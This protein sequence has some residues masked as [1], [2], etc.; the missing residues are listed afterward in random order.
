MNPKPP[1]S[2]DASDR[3]IVLSRVFAAPRELVW[4]AMTDAKQ[5]VHWW[6]PRGFTTTIKEMDFRVGGVW[7][8]TMHGP[9][10]TNYPNESVFQEIVPLERVVYAH[11]GG[12]E[13]GPDVSFTASWTFEGVAADQ[14]RLTLRMV[15]P[16]AEHRDFIVKEFGAVEGGQQTLER[17]SE[18]LAGVRSR[19]FTIT[20]EFAAP[21][22]LVWQIWSERD[23]LMRWFGP[24]GFTTQVARMDLRPGGMFHYRMTTPDG[25]ELWGR[26][27]YR[28]IVPPEKLVWV[29]SFSD[30]D[31][32]VTRHPF[33]SDP[34]PLHLLTVVTFTESAG[35][36]TVQVTWL[37]LD[38]SDAE[39]KT[40]DAGHD[41]MR[42]GWGGTL[43]QLEAYLAEANR[44][45]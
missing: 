15:F 7:R 29:N 23:H 11:G 4:Q 3:E 10:G 6:G 40:F 19:A 21:R 35:R 16:S 5:V 42:M 25:K 28:E 12:R 38:A 18:H 43:E 26:F 20:R 37:P 45:A 44:G 41:S 39:R 31:G 24:K 34:W 22:A 14:T 30:P 2:N 8:H 33:S 27:V 13:G 9:D 36:T 17:L 32:G 1:S